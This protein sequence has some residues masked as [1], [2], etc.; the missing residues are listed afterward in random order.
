MKSKHKLVFKILFWHYYL[1]VHNAYA[2]SRIK[3]RK[4]EV[5]DTVDSRCLTD[6]THDRW[7]LIR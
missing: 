3:I 6:E 1:V 4:H 7:K 5:S 2:I